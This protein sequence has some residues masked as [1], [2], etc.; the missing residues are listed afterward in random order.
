VSLL[1]VEYHDMDIEG[2]EPY[3]EF[4]VLIPASHESRTDVPYLSA[5]N[6]AS[7]GYVWYMPVTTEPAYALGVDI[8][9][10]PKVV[11]DITHEDHGSVRETTVTVDG[12]HFATLAV[13]RP[14]A[15]HVEDDGFWYTRKDGDLLR[16]EPGF[17]ADLGVWPLSS[18]V[19]LD[20]G[21]H[22]KADPLRDLGL[23][24][25]A[26]ARVSAEGTVH[27]EPGEPV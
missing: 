10:Y 25:R 1:S 6:H 14:P 23:G 11:A 19:S 18:A 20:L 22:A 21:E 12:E 13:D 17:D 3:D 7:D 26:L 15:M 8:W 16:I 4:V 9:G 27:L 2:L 24:E 5:L